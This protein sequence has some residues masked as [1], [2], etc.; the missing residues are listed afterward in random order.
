M[1][2]IVVAYDETEESKRALD[3]GVT[4]AQALGSHLIV[5]SVAPVMVSVGRAAGAI[6]P[7]D[8]P[9]DHIEELKR[10]REELEAKG[11]QAEY[12]PA[13]GHL[14][15]AIVEVAKE[16]GADLVVVGTREVGFVKRALGQ[17]VSEGVVH[18][19]ECDLLIV[20]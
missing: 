9:H 12:V 2:T 13:V 11:I 18:K 3:R 19:V 10:V 4:L 15:D 16:K 5:T 6:D 14:D 8:T 17:S 1:K 20:H 7:T